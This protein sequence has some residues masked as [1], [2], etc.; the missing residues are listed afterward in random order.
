MVCT[1]QEVWE[2]SLRTSSSVAS[3]SIYLFGFGKL[4]WLVLFKT[5]KEAQPS[6]NTGFYIPLVGLGTYKITGNQVKP[7]VD[8]A[9]GSGYRMFDTAKYYYN[10][11]EL[12]AALSVGGSNRGILSAKFLKEELF[13]RLQ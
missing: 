12:G 10:E 3:W 8:A 4:K 2:Q 11:Q 13:H 6:F 5:S 9:L 7:A 1:N